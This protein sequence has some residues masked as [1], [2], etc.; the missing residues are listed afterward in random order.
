MQHRNQTLGEALDN[1]FMGSDLYY[2]VMYPNVVVIV[3]DP[4]Q[5]LVRRNAIQTAIREQ[6]KIEQFA[7]GD[8]GKASKNQ[9]I[10]CQDEKSAVY[11]PSCFKTYKTW[12]KTF[13][14]PQELIFHHVVFQTIQ[15][16]V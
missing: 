11:P 5:A 7:F 4:T 12:L 9:V 3:K 14:A 10:F 15:V 2:V 8:P 13:Y 16:N 6:K 1:F